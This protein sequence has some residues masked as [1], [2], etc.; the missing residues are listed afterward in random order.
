MNEEGKFFVFSVTKYKNKSGADAL[1][2]N[3]YGVR[4]IKVGQKLREGE[5][6]RISNK[7]KSVTVYRI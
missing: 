3:A 7:N 6:K 1:G 5:S 2:I 4:N